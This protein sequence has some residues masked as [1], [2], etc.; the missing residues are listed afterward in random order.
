MLVTDEDVEAFYDKN[1][2]DLVRANPAAAT[3][4]RHWT[5]K[6]RELIT[7]ERVNELFEEWLNQARRRSRIDYRPAAFGEG[8]A[9]P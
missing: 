5:R 8:A 4:S 1:R 7:G 2:A 6:I 3:R 9:K